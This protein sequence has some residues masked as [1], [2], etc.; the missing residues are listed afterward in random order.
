MAPTRY[1]TRTEPTSMPSSLLLANISL[2]SQQTK[3]TVYQAS[4]LG[5]E[6][7]ERLTGTAF[8]QSWERSWRNGQKVRRGR[9]PTRDDRSGRQRKAAACRRSLAHGRGKFLVRTGTESDP[10]PEVLSGH[11]KVAWGGIQWT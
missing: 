10:T 1:R 11:R 6:C 4:G 7:F 2:P 8:W 9:A 3:K 5:R